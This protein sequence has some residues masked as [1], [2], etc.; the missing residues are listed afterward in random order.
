MP[1]P[2]GWFKGKPKGATG[3]LGWNI[4]I[5]GGNFP[6]L[7]SPF[8]ENRQTPLKK[9]RSAFERRALAEKSRDPQLEPWIPSWS[10]RA[11][12]S[13]RRAGRHGGQ[14]QHHRGLVQ[15]QHVL[16]GHQQNARQEEHRQDPSRGAASLGC[17]TTLYTEK[18][19]SYLCKTCVCSALKVP[20]ADERMA[21]KGRAKPIDR[22]QNP[23][24]Q[25]LVIWV[26][27]PYALKFV[28]RIWSETRGLLI[29]L[30]LPRGALLPNSVL[31]P[32]CG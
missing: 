10:P 8:L 24:T 12:E 28:G 16:Q 32:F 31:I 9:Q 13:W 14:D 23:S 22:R 7:S 20:E 30:I 29:E 26:G 6:L 1:T 11:L 15:S 18:K 5:S 21:P 19:K 27:V 25:S 17:K 3:K 4:H 2:S